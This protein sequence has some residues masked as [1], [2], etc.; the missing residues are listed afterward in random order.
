MHDNPE[1]SLKERNTSRFLSEILEKEGFSVDRGICGLPTAFDASF[2]KG[3]G[4][5]V[6]LLAEM[7]AL[8]GL[9]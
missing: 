7:D 3:R 9:G 5:K 6:A 4:P 8:P 1:V 2:G